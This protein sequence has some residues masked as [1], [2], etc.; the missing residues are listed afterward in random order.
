MRIDLKNI[1]M[2]FDD[3]TAVDNLNVTINEGELVSLLGPSG[4]GKSTTLFML[5]GLYRPTSGEMLFGDKLVNKVEPENR[6]IGMVFQ[7]YALYPHMTVLKN[8]MFPLKMA[9]IPKK[10]AEERA[11]KMAELVH[12]DHLI[13]RKPGQLSGGQQQRVA[14]ARA[15]VKKPK[16]LL[17][18]EPLSNLD[19]RLRLEMREEIRRIQ[20]EVGITTIFVT[21]DQEEAMSISDKVL[22]MKDGKYQQFSPP[23]DM[24]DHP[25]NIFV[26]Q[27]MGSPPINMIPVSVDM[28]TERIALSGTKETLGMPSRHK[29]AALNCG[30]MVLG[31]RPEDFFVAT[32]NQDGI[33]ARVA[34]VERIGR[35]TLLSAAIGDKQFRALVQP[36]FQG[37][38]NDFVK[39]GIRNDHFHLFDSETEKNILEL[40]R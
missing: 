1:S 9:K 16:L 29:A 19:A 10:E 31:I 20:Q 17:L 4:C 12:I 35:D 24:Y 2:K 21:H 18:D 37:K 25:G 6:E 3:V 5:A 14:I 40:K 13:D 28:E 7:N 11:K 34:L 30:D 33:T 22:L 32:E 15:L 8:I 26:G 36:D 23:Q 38:V 27:F 39:L